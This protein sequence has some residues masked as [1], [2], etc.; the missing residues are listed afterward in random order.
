M[1]ISLTLY[2]IA[3]ILNNKTIYAIKHSK[4]QNLRSKF[5]FI[6]KIYNEYQI[7]IF[8][9]I[10]II[11]IIYRPKYNGPKLNITINNSEK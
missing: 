9:M 7:N 6:Y 8:I 11:I 1:I 10:I 5:F 3:H 4:W 2:K